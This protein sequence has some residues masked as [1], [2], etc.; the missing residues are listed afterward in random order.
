MRLNP[1]AFNA[2]LSGNLAQDVIWR[3]N[4]ICPCVN[5][6]SGAA[7]KRCPRCSGKGRLWAAGI[8]AK[9]GITRQN[10]N[11]K[12]TQQ[13]NWEVGD[14]MLTV[15]ESSPM[16]DA[17][18]FDRVTMLNST[19][20]FSVVLTRGDPTERLYMLIEAIEK[21][22]WYTGDGGFGDE[23]QGGIPAVAD[24]GSLTWA[25]GAPPAGKQYSITG[26]RFAEYFIYLD[27]PSDRAEH[28]GAR[29]PKRMIA[30]RFEVFGR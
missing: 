1:L 14:A 13:V 15:D 23:V 8:A 17:G 12:R 22:Y 30:K 21:V 2:L 20:R 10:I 28:G 19:D 5:P 11:E 6:A 3:P 24:D 26:T 18:Q 4:T 7:N 25:S 27:F 16:Y 9:I 29:L